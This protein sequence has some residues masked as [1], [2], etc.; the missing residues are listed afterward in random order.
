MSSFSTNRSTLLGNSIYCRAKKNKL[1]F[2]A[3]LFC[4]CSRFLCSCCFQLR[5]LS[6][7]TSPVIESGR[8]SLPV[9][10][11]RPRQEVLRAF[12]APDI[13]SATH[14]F[15]S[16][17]P[18][19]GHRTSRLRR[20]GSPLQQRQ[21]RRARPFRP[22]SSLLRPRQESNLYSRL[23]RPVLPARHAS[24]TALSLVLLTGIEPVSLAPEASA[25]SV[26]LQEQ[27]LITRLARRGRR[28]SIELRGLKPQ[29]TVYSVKCS[30][31]I[32]KIRMQ[33]S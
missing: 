2:A 21:Q 8:G 14:S 24:L 13:R 16:R 17:V 18:G 20:L 11:L 28:V 30:V 22:G 10:H 3:S 23:R 29:C 4:F 9:M 7:P 6:L 27:L 1:V 5:H 25:L 31:N 12:R 33:R 32:F 15:Y 19:L 26:E